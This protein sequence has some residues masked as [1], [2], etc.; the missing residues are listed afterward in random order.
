MNSLC[1]LSIILDSNIFR[2]NS[3]LEATLFNPGFDN[4]TLGKQI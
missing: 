1:E 2:L 3:Y 4:R